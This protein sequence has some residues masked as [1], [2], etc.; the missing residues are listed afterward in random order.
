MPPPDATVGLHGLVQR[1]QLLLV[2]AGRKAW[3]GVGDDFDSSWARIAPGLVTVTAATQL[4][5]AR[6]GVEYVPAVLTETDQPDEP[7]AQIRPAAFAGA[8]SD[9]RSLAGLLFG[10]IVTAKLGVARGLDGGDALASG[11][12]W[13]DQTLQSVVA[14][15]AR[16][17]SQ[18]AV[19]VRPKLQWV[20]VVNAPCCSRCAV[21]AGKVFNWNASFD[22]HPQCDCLA[23]PVTVANADSY[24][25]DPGELARRGL[26]T[27]LSR[28]QRERLAGGADLVK[29]LNESRDRWRVRL[30]ADRRARGPVDRLGRSRPAGWA[31]GG[32]NPPAAG[33]T[34]HDLFAKLTADVD[35][36]RVVREMQAAGI[37]A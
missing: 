2:A 26:V 34:I 31:G 35:R 25:T 13:L 16:D 3:S 30:A 9:G 1:L 7:L 11:Q 28:N 18:A 36:N 10:S 27:D 22:R 29:V 21:L 6:A 37:A 23:L 17:A 20:R 24:L 33:S 14:D 5:A 15:A 12:R 19:A 32:T 8:T 4:A